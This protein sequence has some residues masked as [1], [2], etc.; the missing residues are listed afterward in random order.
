MPLA[1][2]LMSPLR[3][4]LGAPRHAL[5][6]RIT[7][8]RPSLVAADVRYG[9]RWLRHRPLFAATSIGTLALGI[10][11]VTAMF[12]IVYG[13]LLKLLPYR[14]PSRLVQLW[15]A[16]PLFN[17]T[18]ATIAPGNAMSWRERN[19]VF[20]S[21]AWYAGSASHA[22]GTSDLTL[23]GD[24]PQHVRRHG[25]RSQLLRRAGRTGGRRP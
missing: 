12:A 23:D 20:E 9:L 21:M 3:F 16:N 8:W 15:E 22:A 18:Q 14:D 2:G 1:A 7:S 10:G 24:P 25:R 4:A 17:W 6:L 19:H 5:A 13:I 11:A